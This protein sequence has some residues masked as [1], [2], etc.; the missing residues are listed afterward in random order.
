LGIS[1]DDL[2]RSTHCTDI[3]L[4]NGLMALPHNIKSTLSRVC[5]ASVFTTVEDFFS[6]KGLT[7]LYQVISGSN[8]KD[9]ALIV[10][11]HV[12]KSDTSATRTLVSFS[13]LL[14]CSQR[15]LWI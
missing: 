1:I 2:Q 14:G 11:N 13:E 5:D 12:D 9:G 15:S 3:T 10:K 6:G 7:K 8:A 4:I